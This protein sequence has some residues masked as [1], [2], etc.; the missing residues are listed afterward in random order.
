M[1]SNTI[2]FPIQKKIVEQD[3]ININLISPPPK[4]PTKFYLISLHQDW[5]AFALIYFKTATL[6]DNK[7]LTVLSRYKMCKRKSVT[8]N[9]FEWKR[10]Y[11]LNWDWKKYM[12]RLFFS[13]GLNIRLT[14]Q[15]GWQICC[16]HL[17]EQVGQKKNE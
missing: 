8:Q 15:K 6:D 17:I 2:Q 9:L 3:K 7:S 4:K 14:C 13:S 5:S 12:Q 10:R 11:C 16:P 1:Q